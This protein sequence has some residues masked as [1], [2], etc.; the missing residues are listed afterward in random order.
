MFLKRNID[1]LIYNLTKLMLH[2]DKIIYY[3]YSYTILKPNSQSTPAKIIT[4]LFKQK[5]N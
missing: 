2:F 3:I 5:I 4:T 1:K